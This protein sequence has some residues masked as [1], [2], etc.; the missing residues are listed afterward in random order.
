[1]KL[2]TACITPFL[3]NYEI[4]F[5][6]F[7]RILYSQK[8]EGNGV[9]LLG[10]TGESLAL[11]VKEKE[12]LVA[13]ACSLKL[14]IPIVVG[15]SGTSLNDA[16]EWMKICHAYPI[17]GFLIPS[18]IYTK[19]GVYGQTLW[20]ESLLNTT[21]KPVILYNIPSRAGT[22]LYLETVGALAS[23]PSC[24]GVKDSGGSIERCREYAQIAPHLVVYCG[25]DSLW[26]QMHSYGA[27]GLI[28]VLSNSWP[29]E[30]R[31]YVD[32]PYQESNT[33]LWQELSLW[34]S[35]TT[36]PIAIK[37][38]LAYKQDIAHSVLRLPLS[39][40]DLQNAEALPNVVEKMLKWSQI[41]PVHT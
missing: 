3:P 37:A 38:V 6:S 29:R 41:Y 2:L 13:F 26:P 16:L 34:L 12:S 8:K 25:D 21:D 24:Y 40:A 14:Q 32:N 33:L 23:H 30:A 11:T 10:S 19:P 18:P 7:E 5:L 31:S 9:V 36:N 15:V 1:M 28:S 22:P 35:L 39:I 17:D 20:F 4:D 27:Q